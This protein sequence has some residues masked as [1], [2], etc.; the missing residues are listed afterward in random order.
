MT[1]GTWGEGAKKSKKIA[2]IIFGSPKWEKHVQTCKKSQRLGCVYPA[3]WLLSFFAF[4]CMSVFRRTKSRSDKW[5]REAQDGRAMRQ[6]EKEEEGQWGGCLGI[7]QQSFISCCRFGESWFAPSGKG[8][9]LPLLLLL[10]FASWNSALLAVTI[11]NWELMKDWV[12]ID[13]STSALRAVTISNRELMK[14]IN[15]NC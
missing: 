9:L 12:L 1:W 14:P 3:F 6:V 5:K 13:N 8:R 10:L 7:R 15:L 2:D 4:S 11:S